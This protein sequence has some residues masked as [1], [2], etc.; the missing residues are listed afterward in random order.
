MFA[1]ADSYSRVNLVVQITVG[2]WYH[3]PDLFVGTRSIID[4]RLR[5]IIPS[6]ASESLFIK[7]HRLVERLSVVNILRPTYNHRYLSIPLRVE[8]NSCDIGFQEY[9]RVSFEFK[10]VEDV[11]Q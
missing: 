1:S 10:G 4:K 8:L 9:A 11:F 3:F 6:H 5:S 2:A 7:A